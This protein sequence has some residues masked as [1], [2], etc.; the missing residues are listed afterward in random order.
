MGG[1]EMT[2]VNY[3]AAL[4][5]DER[6]HHRVVSLTPGGV[7][8]NRLLDLGVEVRDL[9]LARGR[10]SFAAIRQMMGILRAAGKWR[11]QGWMYDGNLLATLVCCLMLRPRRHAWAIHNS[12]ATIAH[13]KRLTRWIIY[14]S[15]LLSRLPAA[16]IYVAHTSARQHE[17]IGYGSHHRQVISNGVDTD[18]FVVDDSAGA[19]LRHDLQLDAAPIIGHVARYNWTKDHATFILALGRLQR[20]GLAFSAVMAGADVDE[21]NE[22]LMALLREQDLLARVRLLGRRDDIPQ[23]MAGFDLFCLSSITESMPLVLVEAMACGVACV[24]TNVGDAPLMVSDLGL[25]VPAED[26]DLLANGLKSALAK[27]LALRTALRAR[28]VDNY[29]VDRM[30]DQYNQLY[31]QL[32]WVEA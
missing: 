4:P 18:R 14:G 20:Q 5:P 24:T 16:I 6:A 25:V 27:P 15:A 21:T 13:E 17:E 11:I 8:A 26:A 28:A 23:I 32:G 1:A 22:A 12:I 2:L 7:L 10:F 30:I 3:L 29:R 31:Q 9:G 19:R